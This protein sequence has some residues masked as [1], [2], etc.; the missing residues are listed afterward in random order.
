MIPARFAHVEDNDT[1]PKLLRHNAR[2]HGGD[3]AFREKKFGLWKSFTWAEF[4][5]HTKL[6]ALALR[7]LGVEQ[8]DTVITSGWSSGDIAS[9]YPFGIPIGKV[10]SVGRQDIELYMR[11]QVEPFVDFDSLSEVVIL[12]AR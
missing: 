12:V 2:R 9:L 4:H 1:L 10:T 7:G 6:W 3:I 5:E 8:G 11:I